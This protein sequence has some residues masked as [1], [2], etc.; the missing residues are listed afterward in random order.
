MNKHFFGDFEIM[1][2]KIKQIKFKLII[3]KE[4]FNYY[5]NALLFCFLLKREL[6]FRFLSID[7]LIKYA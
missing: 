3:Q 4:A 1:I 6:K 5:K 2:L 7:I